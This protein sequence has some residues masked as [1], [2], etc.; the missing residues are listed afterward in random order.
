MTGAGRG[1]GEPPEQAWSQLGPWGNSTKYM[2]HANRMTTL[3][4]QM[5]NFVLAKQDSLPGLLLKMHARAAEQEV[6]VVKEISEQYEAATRAGISE[7]EVHH[8]I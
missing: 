1:A 2:S 6:D 5:V 4:K 3:E 7:E 8:Q